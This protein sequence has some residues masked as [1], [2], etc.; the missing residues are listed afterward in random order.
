VLEIPVQPVPNQTLQAQLGGQNCRINIAQKNTGLYVD[1]YVDESLVIGGVIGQNENRIVRSEYLGFIGD[2]AFVD[3]R[4]T[5][6]PVYTGLGSRFK[7]IYL[8]ETDLPS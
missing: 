6:D 3:T 5:T 1:L 7:L 8:E 2:L 4:G